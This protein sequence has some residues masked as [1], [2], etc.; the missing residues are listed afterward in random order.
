[1]KT[2]S[3]FVLLG[4]AVLCAQ[5]TY[6]LDWS[7][8]SGGAQTD[9]PGAGEF[10]IQSTLGQITAVAPAGGT[11]GEYSVS[12]GYWTFTLDEPLDLDLG[13]TMQLNG[14]AVTLTWDDSTGIPVR[15]ESSADLQIWV[16]VNPQ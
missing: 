11:P 13:L 5:D 16:P 14:A 12:S 15:L 4:P 10:T 1:M 3:L 6:T 8:I 9:N 7:S 2:C